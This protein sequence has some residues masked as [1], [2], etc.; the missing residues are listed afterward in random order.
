MKKRFY[1]ITTLLL[2]SV[3]IVASAQKI[4]SLRQQIQMIVSA[5]NADVGVAVMGDNKTDTLS[6]KGDKHFPMQSVFKFHIAL[7]VLSEVDKG[8]FALDQKITIEEK[9]L[10]PG[11]YSPLREKYPHGASLPISE[12]LE[13]TVSK[14]DNVGCDVLL[15]LLGG[16]QVVEQYFAT[17]GF[18]DVSIKINEETMQSDWDLQFQ[19]W[20]TPKAATHVLASFF[21]NK[22]NLLSPKSHNFIW[23]T[24]KQTETGRARLKGQLP[25]GTV[26]GHKTGFSGTNSSGITAA[27]ND[28]GIIFLPNGRHFFISVF[29]T[30]SKEDIAVNEKI[31]ADVSKVAW[32]FFSSKYSK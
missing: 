13:Y 14:S 6:W 3:S 26:V 17:N 16:P 20:T 25:S 32:D 24:M 8:R 22:E 9:D 27:V 31:I 2:T 4:E 15:T 11:L 28:I 18:K 5:N 1:F 10:L 12:I 30:N 7:V 23:N 21:Y 19:N 29:V